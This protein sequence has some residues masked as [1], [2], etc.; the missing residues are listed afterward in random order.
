MKPH[1][2]QDFMP[3]DELIKLSAGGGGVGDPYLRS[4]EAVLR[5]V[6][7]GYVS[8]SAA[9]TLY[10]VVLDETGTVIDQEATQEHRSHPAPATVV[11]IDENSL[12]IR[13]VAEASTPS[14]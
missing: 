6:R 9:R 7:D 13:V 12:D 8:V 2:M 1:R 4:P 14:R 10:G 3:G 11:E 5:D